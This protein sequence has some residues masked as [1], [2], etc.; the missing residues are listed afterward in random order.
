[1]L[2][3]E[4]ESWLLVVEGPGSP[5][6]FR[7]RGWNHK[8]ELIQ[9]P[10]EERELT[11][12]KRPYSQISCSRALVLMAMVNRTWATSSWVGEEKPH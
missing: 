8:A 3:R 11:L 2:H 4:E 9:A 7:P 1:M 6:H 10:H 12:S 5:M